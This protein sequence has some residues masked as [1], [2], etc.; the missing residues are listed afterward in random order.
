M[1]LDIYHHKATLNRPLKIDPFSENFI[2]ESEFDGFDVPFDYFQ[3]CIQLIDTPETLET[4]IFSKRE[5]E[6]DEVKSF[7]KDDSY[8]YLFEKDKF[9]LNKRVDEFITEKKLNGSLIHSW[10]T[11][12]WFGFHVFKYIKQTGFYYEELGYQC[13]GMGGFFGEKFYADEDIYCFT[14]KEDF[15]FALSCIDYSNDTKK[16]VEY[17]KKLFKENFVDKYELHKSWMCLSY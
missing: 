1:G 13:K 9:N 3:N 4:I 8:H 15:E 5:N 14:K 11:D 12:S 2:I 17:N 6:M 7:L 16:V 10:E